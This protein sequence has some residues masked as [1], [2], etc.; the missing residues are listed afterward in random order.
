MSWAD[1]SQPH[2]PNMV[3]NNAHEY[4]YEAV[5]FLQQED[6]SQNQ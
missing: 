1:L 4:A 3:N 5:F 2:T 6:S